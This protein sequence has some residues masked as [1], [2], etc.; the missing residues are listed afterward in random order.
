MPLSVTLSLVCIIG[1]LAQFIGL[2]MVRGV[3]ELKKGKP[4]FLI[5]IL[6]SG[7]LS[8]VA[9]LFTSFADIPTNFKTFEI[10]IW[11]AIG[12][13]LFGFGTAFNQGCGVSTLGKLSR[14]DSKMIFTIL[15]WLI[16]WSILAKWNPSISHNKFIISSDITIGLLGILS[17]ILVVWA[18]LGNKERRKLWSTMMLIGLIGGFVFL[19]DPKWP[20]SGLL[21]KISN[22]IVNPDSSLWPPKESY[23]LFIALL[24]GMFSAA[25][26][27]KTFEVIGSNLKE[28]SLH[29]MAGTFMGIGA[30]L[31]LGGNDTQLL[32]ALPTFSP[33]GIVA[34]LG[35]LVGIWVGLFVREK[36]LAK[37]KI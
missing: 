16:D 34:V 22:A 35:M 8:W 6:C 37:I 30:S 26:Y 14:G 13:L 2:C 36:G 27:T 31:A 15:G 23:F 17:I 4:E 10:N 19:F 5:A 12:G 20:P 28:W 18:F 24:I 7:V 3:N 29:I 25:L 21:L 11:F 9:M 33:A 32:L 1:Y